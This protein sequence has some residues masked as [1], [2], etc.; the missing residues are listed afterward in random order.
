MLRRQVV[1]A[2]CALVATAPWHSAAAAGDAVPRLVDALGTSRSFKVRVQAANLLGRLKDPRGFQALVRAALE[3]PHPA[4]RAVAVRSLPRLRIEGDQ[5]RLAVT[6]AL[7]DRD[8]SV[9]RQAAAS[10]AELQRIAA[11]APR[12]GPTVVAVGAVGDRTGRSSRAFRDRLRA[13]I[14]ALIERE[15][16]VKLAELN[17]PGVGYVVDVS[18]SRLDL[19]PSGVD[20]E[21]IC[22]IELVV[23]RP[24]RGII[25]VASGEAIV[26]KPRRM[27]KPI[28]RESMETEALEA[29]VRSAHE[30][31]SRFLATA[32]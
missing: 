15:P 29:A 14:R 32:P 2:L 25:T 16:R 18:I 26:G 19:A 5:A 9:R 30:S 7:S 6:R 31:L 24:P 22:A 3:D 20:M 17:T 10:M 23:S 12:R 28:L 11:S 8:P 13:E 21:A 4:V 1:M 27:Y